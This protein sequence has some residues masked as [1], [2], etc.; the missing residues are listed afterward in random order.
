MHA[1]CCRRLQVTRLVDRDDYELFVTYL[2]TSRCSFVLWT[3]WPDRLR[4]A[5]LIHGTANA[6]YSQ[7]FSPL[8]C[9]RQTLAHTFGYSQRWYL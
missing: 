3:K 8:D 1:G 9:R 2:L 7:N 5:C 4:C 6:G